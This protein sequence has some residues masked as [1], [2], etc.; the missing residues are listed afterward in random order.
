MVIGGD[1]A[2]VHAAAAG[3]RGAG[4]ALDHAGTSVGHH[5]EAVTADWYGST[6]VAAG[7]VIGAL[8]TSTLSAADAVADCEQVYATYA[9]E[10]AAAKNAWQAGQELQVAGEAG[11]RSAADAAMAADDRAADDPGRG[12]AIDAARS[13]SEA[14]GAT[15][16]RGQ[17]MMDDAVAREARANQAAATAV[18]AI[19]ERLDAV[20][21]AHPSV[22]GP[23]L[24]P[25][26][27]VLYGPPSPTGP[28][29]P[30][31]RDRVPGISDAGSSRT[32]G[33][34]DPAGLATM[35]LS[36]LPGPGEPGRPTS[37]PQSDDAE[38]MGRWWHD[39]LLGKT[40][41]DEA[42]NRHSPSYNQVV[43]LGDG[44]WN[45]VPGFVGETLAGS[46]YSW[47]RAGAPPIT[48]AHDRLADWA[49][50]DV[51]SKAYRESSE[52]A[53]LAAGILVPGPGGKGKVLGEVGDVGGGI[54][55]KGVGLPVPAP[56]SVEDLSPASSGGTAQ[57]WGQMPKL[58]KHVEDHGADFGIT[59]PDD[60]A[61][62]ANDFRQRIDDPGVEVKYE[63]QPNGTKV[64]RMYEP[65]TN[66]FG[67]FNIDGTT[68]TFYKPER[69]M[70][71]WDDQKGDILP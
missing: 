37:V 34:G 32:P 15:A 40:P 62:A 4:T 33:V 16:A 36:A 71:Y 13:A 66:T 49:G 6:A 53:E 39:V 3:L 18:D 60:Y 57:T 45:A 47:V 35:G 9:D 50:A 70:D 65:S 54:V 5:G 25:P 23:P 69:G 12:A 21:A 26:V 64:V 42:G 29:A 68:K 1:P 30:G 51:G 61:R 8:K 43:G 11:Q 2:G 58:Q 14:A 56:R 46:P 59:D 44:A 41:A 10:L 20:A 67:S 63:V 28:V 22:A 19:V 17:T 52:M 27:P 24:G 55:K 48:K 31:Y 38:R 7:R